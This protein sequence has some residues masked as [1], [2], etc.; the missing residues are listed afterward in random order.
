LR[1]AGQT[2]D[3]TTFCFPDSVFAPEHF[4]TA[5]RFDLIRLAEE[6]D[7][8]RRTDACEATHGGLLDDYIEAHVH[9]TLSLASDVEALVLDPCFVGTDVERAA[10]RL[11]VQIEWHEG[12]VLAVDELEHHPEFRGP[13]IVTVGRRIAEHGLL[14]ARIIGQAWRD[15]TEDPQDL[16]RVWHHVARFGRPAN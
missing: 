13:R 10:D 15:G 9:G 6:F 12:R 2:L 1:L 8:L 5:Q 14:D 7:A 16:K 4:G 3:R 11:G